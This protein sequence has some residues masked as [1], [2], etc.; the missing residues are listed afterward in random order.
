MY[1]V[2][3]SNPGFLSLDTLDILGHKIICSGDV[4]Y[5]GGCLASFLTSTNQMS[6]G[7]IPPPPKS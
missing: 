4:L 1:E 6:V 3:P 5:T 2:C 7:L